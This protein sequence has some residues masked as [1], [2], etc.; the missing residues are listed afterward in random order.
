MDVHALHPVG[1]HAFEA[2]P[3]EVAGAGGDAAEGV[4][5]H[6]FHR[7]SGYELAVVP[8]IVGY[9]HIFDG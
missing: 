2:E 3:R 9:P 7:K 6:T 1:L 8:Q 4:F 5:G